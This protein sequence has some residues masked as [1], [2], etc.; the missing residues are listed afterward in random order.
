MLIIMN[1]YLFCRC[2]RIGSVYKI[3]AQ[4]RELI[5]TIILTGIIIRHLD[6]QFF[7]H[8]ITRTP[9]IIVVHKY[10]VITR[11]SALPSQIG[12]IVTTVN[13]FGFS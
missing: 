3:L 6:I 2:L 9:G 7:T 13:V 10:S 11:E 1:R 5:V 4:S 12:T 8:T